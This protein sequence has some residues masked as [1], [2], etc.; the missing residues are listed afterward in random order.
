MEVAEEATTEQCLEDGDS[1]DF[2]AD[3]S[4]DPPAWCVWL[5]CV[6]LFTIIPQNKAKSEHYPC[7][8]LIIILLKSGIDLP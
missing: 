8:T 7:R 6:S 4:I 5:I 1:Q 3:S 2:L